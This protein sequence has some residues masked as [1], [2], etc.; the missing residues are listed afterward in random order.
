MK[1]YIKKAFK[2]YSSTRVMDIE[3]LKFDEGYVYA[4]LGLNGS[5]KTTLLECIA[6]FSTLSGG[7]ILYNETTD[8]T[9]MRQN[10]S[11][12]AQ[13][14]YLFNITAYNNLISG[15]KFKKLDNGEILKR[16]KKYIKYFNIDELL[17]KN[18]KKLSGGESA[19]VAMLR[20]AVLETELTLL[21]EPTASMDIESTLKAEDLI[22]DMAKGGRSVIIVTHDLYQAQRIADYVIFMDRGIVIE[23]GKKYKVLNNPEHKLV[24]LILNI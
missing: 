4:V 16:V 18:A 2:E 12:M 22:K 15:L 21:D 6:G 14:P 10:I 20:T 5:G 9:N 11:I 13:K 1:V 8:I 17:N 7:S 19:K 24:K 23:M 3:E